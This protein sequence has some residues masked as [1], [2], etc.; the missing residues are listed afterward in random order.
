VAPVGACR[1]RPPAVIAVKRG[2]CASARRPRKPHPGRGWGRRG[3]CLPYL[4]SPRVCLRGPEEKTTPQ[5]L[6]SEVVPRSPRDRG[7]APTPPERDP[8]RAGRERRRAGTTRRPSPSAHRTASRRGAGRELRNGSF[9]DERVVREG[10]DSEPLS[11]ATHPPDWTGLDHRFA[12]LECHH[13]RSQRAQ[14]S[15]K[16]LAPEPPC[17]FE[18]TGGFVSQ[19]ARGSNR[20]WERIGP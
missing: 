5:Q 13:G 18:T 2:R 7:G 19:R 6:D 14:G 10:E 4:G 9:E 11:L 15:G 16:K 17:D 8:Q 20:L 3:S 1:A 12:L